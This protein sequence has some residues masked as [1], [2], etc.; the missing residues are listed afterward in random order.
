MLPPARTVTRAALLAAAALCLGGGV[1]GAGQP[2]GPLVITT[3]SDAYC[4]TLTKAIDGHRPLPREVSD[5]ERQGQ[6]LCGSGRVRS[7]IVRLRR[8]LLVLQG[9]PARDTA[10]AP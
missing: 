1:R 10:D 9:S 5:L 2:A 7:G 8:A 4:Q 3:D 6:A